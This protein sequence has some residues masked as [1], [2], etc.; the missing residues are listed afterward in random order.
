MS[1]KKIFVFLA[2]NVFCLCLHAES[3]KFFY[4]LD[5]ESVDVNSVTHT[6]GI[7]TF[8]TVDGFAMSTF[9]DS[10]MGMVFDFQPTHI[11][12]V[13]ANS[14][15]KTIKVNWN[16]AVFVKKGKVDKIFHSGVK[17]SDRTNYQPPTLLL[18]K[19]EYGDII[20]PTSNV[21]YSSY[22]SRWVYSYLLY[23]EEYDNSRVQLMLPIV[24]DDSQIEYVFNFKA[25]YVKEKVKVKFTNDHLVH[26]VK[27]KQ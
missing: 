5:L 20:I 3:I 16:D 1:M 6:D 9:S 13:I 10:I 17:I 12:I 2:L 21:E 14:L 27:R 26:Y 11:H 15:N 18:K 4:W 7:S 23:G 8:K 24:V 19:M 25:T 22:L